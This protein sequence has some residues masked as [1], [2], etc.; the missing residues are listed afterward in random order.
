M[1]DSSRA[2]GG[3]DGG[4]DEGR[5]GWP[6]AGVLAALAASLVSMATTRLVCTSSPREMFTGRVYFVKR[7]A[8][9]GASLGGVY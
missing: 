8:L 3:G 6:I 1:A 2:G 4:G 7:C 9:R 5:G